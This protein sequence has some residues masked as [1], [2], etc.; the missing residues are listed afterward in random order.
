M[1]ECRALCGVA[2]ALPQG[3]ARQAATGN[4]CDASRCV[5]ILSLVCHLEPG[6]RKT[7]LRKIDSG[8]TAGWTFL[9]P[10]DAEHYIN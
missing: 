2:A 9:A 4:L 1:K 10:L 5:L 3:R 8:A 6:R 7:W